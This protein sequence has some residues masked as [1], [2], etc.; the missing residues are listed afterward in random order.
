MCTGTLRVHRQVHSGVRGL[1]VDVGAEEASERG[2]RGK[3]GEGEGEGEREGGKRGKR[4]TGLTERVLTRDKEGE[5]NAA[6]KVLMP[7]P[8]VRVAHRG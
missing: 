8:S 3:E 5:R 7:T 2:T 1:C 4:D 6:G